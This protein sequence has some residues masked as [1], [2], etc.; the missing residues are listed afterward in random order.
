[1]GVIAPDPHDMMHQPAI[2]LANGIDDVTS[3]IVDNQP[4]QFVYV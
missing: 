1:M 2:T 4:D 3:C